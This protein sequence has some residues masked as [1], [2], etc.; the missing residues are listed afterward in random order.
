MVNKADTRHHTLNMYRMCRFNCQASK[1]E[2]L[3]CVLT[4]YSE[5]AWCFLVG[6]A[7]GCVWDSRRTLL[8]AKKMFSSELAVCTLQTY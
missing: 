8:P 6:V 3:G 1:K 5:A 4:P 2:H 7:E